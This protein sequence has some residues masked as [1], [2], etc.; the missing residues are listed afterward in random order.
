MS[1]PQSSR[2]KAGAVLCAWTI[3][4]LYPS[5]GQLWIAH[6]YEPF[7]RWCNERLRAAPGI[8]YYGDG[9]ITSAKLAKPEDVAA[10]FQTINWPS[11]P[12]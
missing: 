8:S 5:L 2:I 7:G 6:F 3:R 4:P 11:D 9:G 10:H 1:L 12:A